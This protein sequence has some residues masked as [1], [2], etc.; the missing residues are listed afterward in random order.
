MG[1]T[2]K[3]TRDP[4]IR[5]LVHEVDS[6]LHS[7]SALLYQISQLKL[8]INSKKNV[9]NK[10]LR[11]LTHPE[12]DKIINKNLKLNEDEPKKRIYSSSFKIKNSEENLKTKT[13]LKQIKEFDEKE[14]VEDVKIF[15]EKKIKNEKQESIK[16]EK[17]EMKSQK[18]KIRRSL[19]KVHQNIRK[20][21]ATDKLIKNIKIPPKKSPFKLKKEEFSAKII[22]K[23]PKNRI[24]RISLKNKKRYSKSK[25]SF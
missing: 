13:T 8:K 17:N 10:L 11:T 4:E 14:P 20:S 6:H 1:N 23:I 12:S 18:R 5:A 24:K 15:K 21:I 3:I 22:K 19:K 9:S 2:N 7:K 16:K 25:T